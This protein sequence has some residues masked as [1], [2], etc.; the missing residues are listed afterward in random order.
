MRRRI[1][2]LRSLGRWDRR[3]FDAVASSNSRVL[4]TLLPP[5]TRS[6]DNA[7]MWGLVAAALGATGSRRLRRAALRAV[8]SVGIASPVANIAG[9]RLFRRARPDIT[10][11]PAVRLAKHVPGSTGFPSGHSAT[12][13]AFAVAV[14]AEAP[15]PVAV[16]VLLLAVGVGVS[17]VYT[18]VHYP[19]DVL[20]GMALGAA[21]GLLSERLLPPQRT[22]ETPAGPAADGSVTSRC[23][24]G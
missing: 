19:G 8:V 3:A 23:G 11:V 4:D 2:P 21:C 9:K 24:G 22:D 18:G 15:L 1:T 13:A 6:A 7:A 10:G 5:L 16:P 17:R 20:A 12:A 14:A